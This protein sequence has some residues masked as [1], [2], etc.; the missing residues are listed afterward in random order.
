MHKI[1]K[2]CIFYIYREY[3]LSLQSNAAGSFLQK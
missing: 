2:V 3:L 1:E